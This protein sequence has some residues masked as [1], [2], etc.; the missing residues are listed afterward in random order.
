M[1]GCGG[2]S[3]QSGERVRIEVMAQFVVVT[4]LVS[5]LVGESI[6][7]TGSAEVEVQG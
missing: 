7:L 4:P 3:A 2:S 1:T 5:N 6:T